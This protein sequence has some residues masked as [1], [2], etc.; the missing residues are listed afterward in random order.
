[1]HEKSREGTQREGTMEDTNERQYQDYKTRE[2]KRE[3]ALNTSDDVAY[4]LLPEFRDEPLDTNPL[5]AEGTDDWDQQPLEEDST[6]FAETDPV[7]TK[8]STGNVEVLNGFAATSLSDVQVAPSAEGPEPGDEALA[9]AVRRQLLEDALTT[10]L[11]IDVSV[12]DGVVYL[13]GQVPDLEDA[14]NAEGV[15]SQVPGV[16]EV[17][18]ELDLVNE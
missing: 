18:E 9:A 17:S 16:R 6:Y 12:E 8:D 11:E 15:A 2:S 10:A 13:R 3:K 14:Q 1:M 7:I 4:D 5:V